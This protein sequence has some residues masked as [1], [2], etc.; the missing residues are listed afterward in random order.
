[1]QSFRVKMFFW[2][3]LLFYVQGAGAVEGFCKQM[4]KTDNH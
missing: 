2:Q 1:M 3:F 4:L